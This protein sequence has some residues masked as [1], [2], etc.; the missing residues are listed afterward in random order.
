MTQN[1]KLNVSV[2]SFGNAG[3]I[4]ILL[5]NY[6][7]VEAHNSKYPSPKQNVTIALLPRFSAPL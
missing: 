1:V 3:G 2:G 6:V 7:F 4:V 5:H